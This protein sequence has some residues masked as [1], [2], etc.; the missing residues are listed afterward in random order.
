MFQI[1]FLK[2]NLLLLSRKFLAL[3][4]AFLLT[5]LKRSLYTDKINNQLI[6]EWKRT[7]NMNYK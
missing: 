4:N 7:Q 6:L 1:I 5:H 2:T 3:E